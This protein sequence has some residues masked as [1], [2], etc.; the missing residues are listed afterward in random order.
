MVVGRWDDALTTFFTGGG[1]VFTEVKGVSPPLP[2]TQAIEAP[3]LRIVEFWDTKLLN[4]GYKR[5]H[6]VRSA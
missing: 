3:K 2:S 1:T 5:L 6:I 4:F